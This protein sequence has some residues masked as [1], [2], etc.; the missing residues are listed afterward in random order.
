MHSD[1]GI[2]EA[3]ARSMGSDAY[4]K[5]NALEREVVELKARLQT[6]EKIVRYGVTNWPAG[7]VWRSGCPP[8]DTRTP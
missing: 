5:V 3:M 2:G 6:L 8:E 7:I 1:D 4:T